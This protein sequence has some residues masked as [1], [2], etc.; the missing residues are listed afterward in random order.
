MISELLLS[1]ILNF[2]LCAATLDLQV[3][4]S[5][6]WKPWR[7]GTGPFTMQP[8]TIAEPVPNTQ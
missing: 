3:L 4:L 5:L 8:G 7:A 6:R 1:I 2:P